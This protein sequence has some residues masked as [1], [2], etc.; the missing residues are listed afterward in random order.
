M[1]HHLSDTAKEIMSA[2]KKGQLNKVQELFEQGLAIEDINQK[3]FL[4]LNV[5]LKHG[6]WRIAKHLLEQQILPV[7]SDCPAMIA[8]TQYNKDL[9]QGVELVFSHTADLD[10][11]DKNQRTALMT[12]CLLGHERKVKYLLQHG[13]NAAATDKAGMNAFLDAVLSQSIS[14]I[15]ML[16]AHDVD[17]THCND[18]GDNALSIAMQQAS[19][20]IR[21]I[22]TLL[23]Y[24]VDPTVKNKHGKSAFSVA[25]K[26]HSAIF[27]LFVRKI[28]ADKQI[29]LPLFGAEPTPPKEDKTLNQQQLINDQA[30]FASTIKI[31]TKN[32]VDAA[33]DEQWFNA[34]A[35]GNL[36]KISQLLNRGVP[37]DSIDQ[38]GCTGLIH[39][40]GK[41]HRAVASFLIQNHAN[42]EHHSKNGSTALSSAI[43]SNSGNLVGLLL[44]H[45]ADAN[46]KGPGGYPYLSLAASQWSEAAVSMLVDAGGDLTTTD[47]LGMSLYHHVAIAAEYYS[48]TAKAKSTLRLIHQFGLDINTLN[49]QGNSALHVIC[50]AAKSKKYAVD[51]VQIATIAH[52]LLKLGANPKLV[53]HDGFTAIQYA[54]KHGLMNTNG[55]LLSYIEAW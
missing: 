55:V 34:I 39:A 28:E 17:V 23:S 38:R 52:E 46:G 27:K 7:H 31:T 21:V 2:C 33:N 14:I 53:N 30:N 45:G 4:P 9:T 5:A 41:G 26:K 19:P 11:V 43:I 13:D 24:D 51:D 3:E 50:G 54:K 32:T 40:A 37:V 49:K 44:K 25:E 29:E 10:V 1:S 6:R 16:A 20:N 22:K 12:A 18:A 47:D 36:G 35:D 8:A 15:E 42:I 48:N